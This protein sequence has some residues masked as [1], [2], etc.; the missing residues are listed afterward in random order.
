MQVYFVD[1][2]EVVHLLK[3]RDFNRWMLPHKGEVLRDNGWVLAIPLL[4][5]VLATG[6]VAVSCCVTCGYDDA[7]DIV[8]N[9]LAF[10]FISEVPEMFNQP[11]IKYGS[12]CCPPT[13]PCSHWSRLF[14]CRLA[15]AAQILS[16]CELLF[17]SLMLTATTPTAQVLLLQGNRGP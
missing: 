15:L 8:L 7:F 3:F 13:A 9:S 6:V 12:T 16:R 10:T 17:V 1:F 5:Y 4:R 2:T 14:G 11:L